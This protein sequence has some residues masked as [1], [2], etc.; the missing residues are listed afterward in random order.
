MKDNRKPLSNI[1]Y[2]NLIFAALVLV[3]FF[4]AL[5]FTDAFGR[6]FSENLVYFSDNWHDSAGNTYNLDIT[7][8]KSFAGNVTLT[9]T[10]PDDLKDGDSL[11]FLSKYCNVKVYMNGDCIYAYEPK[12]N[13]TGF[14][15][16]T[17]FHSVGLCEHDCGKSVI[18]E[19]YRLSIKSRI[20]EVYNVYLGQSSD[21]IHM[22]VSQNAI[23][24][25][26]TLLII[27]FGFIIILIW[28]GASSETKNYLTG[29][30]TISK[31]SDAECS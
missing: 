15:E 26:L 25:F 2:Y 1:F 16:G 23:S 6:D 5:F 24:L 18:I 4:Y 29:C 31:L 21:Y 20:G 28:L 11:C 22:M 30:S 13:L 12:E 27:F 10:L 8:L 17:V 7:E 9:N 14:G 19:I 3:V